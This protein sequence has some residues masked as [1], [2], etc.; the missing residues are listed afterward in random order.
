VLLGFITYLKDL[1]FLSLITA[2]LTTRIPFPIGKRNFLTTSSR[3]S[4]G[5]WKLM[6]SFFAIPWGFHCWSYEETQSQPMQNIWIMLTCDLACS[7]SPVSWKKNQDKP[8]FIDSG[9]F[10]YIADGEVPAASFH[11]LPT[12]TA[13]LLPLV[14]A[15]H[16]TEL[17]AKPSAASSQTSSSWWWYVSPPLWHNFQPHPQYSPPSEPMRNFGCFFLWQ[18]RIQHTLTGSYLYVTFSIATMLSKACGRVLGLGTVL[19]AK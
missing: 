5:P 2:D 17:P 10:S 3:L 14:L 4:Q 11:C 8:I 19:Q 9:L 13:E 1:E 12:G 6:V 15:G 18:Q 16:L 7:K